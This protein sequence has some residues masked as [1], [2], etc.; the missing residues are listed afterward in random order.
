[1]IVAVLAPGGVFA[2]SVDELRQRLQRLENSTR[3]ELESLKRLIRE[4]EAEREKERKAQEEQERVLESLKQQVEEQRLSFEERERQFS[5]V[6]ASWANF[7]DLQAGRKQA[8]NDRD[9]LGKDIQGNVFTSDSFKVRLGG[10]LRFHVQHN[11]SPVGESVSRA[12]LPD[13]AP[14]GGNTGRG[15]R[16]NFRAFAGRSRLN[17]AM[18]GPDT[19]GGKTSAFFEMD[20]NQQANGAGEV[21]AVNN[22]PRLR[23]AYGQWAFPG[24]LTKDDELQIKLGQTS[25]FADGFPDSIDFNTML[26]GL[27]AANRRNPRIEVIERF[28]LLPGM[29]LLAS[30]GAERPLFDNQALGG[31]D[32]AAR[33]LG[34][35]D[36]SGFPALSG[37]IGFEAGRLG[38][39]GST[40]FYARGTWGERRERFNVG[41][42]TP[43]LNAQTNFQDRNFT[44]QVVHGT[45]ILDRIG[46]NETGRAMTLKLQGGAVWTRGEGR[47]T[48]SDFDRRVIVD[49]DGTLK[50]A[51][52]VGAWVNPMFFFTD[53]LS[54]RWAGGFQTALN[55][56]RPVVTGSLITDSAGTNFFRVNNRQSE[57]S[58]W[59]TPG[60]FTFAFGW[61][62]TKTDFRNVNTT[63]TGSTSRHNENNKFEFISWWSF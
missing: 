29:K 49:T 13:A 47:V 24:L 5:P 38:L 62:F 1:M 27:G 4:G 34:S 60:P 51:Q 52:S 53:T 41:T 48:N 45:L 18:Q 11:D 43:S 30:L 22:N 15:E 12:L 25:A 14:G 9:P 56:D 33:D 57:I 26:A 44:D 28:P 54:L 10:S 35:G 8:N 39:I 2:Q 19:L 23:H 16:E 59:W 6:P 55:D 20:F 21:N 50:S 32:V 61:N 42:T 58:L 31:G 37:G 17:L 3:E 63:G 46:F 36:L 40:A 7:F